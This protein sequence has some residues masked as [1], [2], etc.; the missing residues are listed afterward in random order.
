ME[1]FLE[2]HQDRIQGIIAGMDRILFRGNLS[3]LCHLGG[4]ERFLSS[5]R[6][7]YKDVKAFALKI[8]A[9][10]NAPAEAVAQPAG[11]PCEYVPSGQASKEEIARAVAVLPNGEAWVV[12]ETTL[13]G[14]WQHTLIEHRTCAPSENPRAGVAL[15]NTAAE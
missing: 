2:R 11:H 3:N 15:P 4:M 10:I 5:Q 14:G 12:G 1:R 7:R 13:S 8:S 6:V 9:R